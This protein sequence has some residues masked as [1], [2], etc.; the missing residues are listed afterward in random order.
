M[1]PKRENEFSNYKIEAIRD[2]KSQKTSTEELRLFY[3][4]NSQPNK[5]GIRVVNK[6]FFEQIVL[7]LSGDTM[8]IVLSDTHEQI[9]LSGTIQIL[10][11]SNRSFFD[12]HQTLL[13]P[14]QANPFG[15]EPS[16]ILKRKYGD[17]KEDQ[18][19]EKDDQVVGIFIIIINIREHL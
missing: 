15:F 12:T 5:F 14:I 2:K 9:K 17:E 8:N 18:K 19:G 11:S 6:S 1:F 10:N 4:I 3:S 7:L 13:P 16:S